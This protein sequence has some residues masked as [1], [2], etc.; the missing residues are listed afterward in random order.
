MQAILIPLVFVFLIGACVGSFL[1]VVVWRL[2]RGE[3]LVK[4][5]SH[6]PKCNTHLAWFDNIPILGWIMLRGKCRYCKNPISMRYP[7]IESITALIFFGYFLL[8]FAQH[9]GMIAICPGTWQNAV[10]VQDYPVYFLYMWLLSALL[11]SSL[12]DAELFIIEPTVVWLTGIVGIL[13]HCF[14]DRPDMPG[15]LSTGSTCSAAFAAGGGI[16]WFIAGVLWYRGKLPVSFPKGEPII[17]AQRA[18]FEREI[19]EARKRGEDAP[20]LPPV[21]SRKQIRKEVLKEA[22]FLTPGIV[23]G[24]LCMWLTVSGRP[25]DALWQ[26]LMHNNAARGLLGALLGGMIGGLTIWI[27]RILGTLGFGRVAMGRGDAD[28]MFAVGAVMG[29]TA[30]VYVFFTA[31]F[32]GILI[33]LYLSIRKKQFEM[34]YGPYLSLATAAVIIFY[35]P[36]DNYFGAQISMVLTLLLQNLGLC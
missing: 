3:S 15:T 18:D 7:I 4:P 25:L 17:E 19:R 13:F 1:N 24:I 22:L 27:A 2:P 34:P 11:A 33:A 36:L 21:Y 29:A 31:P 32:F 23:L 6:C 20:P 14:M 35:R 5:P 9:R 12:I 26:K 8:T 28:L 10:F 16:G 30:S